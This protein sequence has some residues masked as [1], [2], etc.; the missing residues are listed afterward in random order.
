MNE[1]PKFSNTR[2]KPFSSHWL[3]CYA[4]LLILV[5]LISFDL[6]SPCEHIGF[7][8]RCSDPPL[9]TTE[10]CVSPVR[11]TLTRTHTHSQEKCALRTFKRTRSSHDS[12]QD[13]VSKTCVNFVLIDALCTRSIQLTSYELLFK[14]ITTVF[15]ITFKFTEARR[16]SLKPYACPLMD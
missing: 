11:H 4:V 3:Y 6:S 7:S 2:E 10:L 5:Y 14:T 15:E 13:N 8:V 1:W 16:K 9:H 12:F